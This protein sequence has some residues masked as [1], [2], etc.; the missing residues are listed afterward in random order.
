VADTRQTT[1]ARETP[2]ESATRW[3]PLHEAPD[4][5]QYIP[6]HE[7]ERT[8]LALRNA[9]A[10]GASRLAV[11]GPPGL[12]KTLLLRLLEDQTDR[13]LR[14]FYIPFASLE[15]HDLA[16]WVLALEGRSA[17]S[18]PERE[19][20]NVVAARHRDRDER[21][22][23]LVDEAQGIGVDT[24][25]RLAHWV[26]E[27]GGA[28]AVVLAG[29]AGA[30]VEAALRGLGAE[31]RFELNTP[32]LEAELAAFADALVADLALS[33]PRRIAVERMLERDLW[34]KT[35]GNPRL[36][37]GEILRAL[38]APLA[39]GAQ[40]PPDP[41]PAETARSPRLESPTPP[42][43]SRSTSAAGS[44]GSSRAS[45]SSVWPRTGVALVLG[46]LIA[47]WAGSRGFDHPTEGGKVPAA[48][49]SHAPLVPEV[50]PFAGPPRLDS[51]PAP[52][53]RSGPLR[54]PFAPPSEV[55]SALAAP[56]LVTVAINA[57]PWARVR[58]DGVEVGVTPIGALRLSPGL[59]RFAAEFPDGRLVEREV[60]VREGL[61]VVFP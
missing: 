33:A 54:S 24:A 12:G 52:P 13:D 32:I 59:R 49:V 5:R 18:A 50:P 8:L 31:L 9:L 1:R 61:R 23:L 26:E 36:V 58:V 15:P 6:R 41:P 56:R 29:I 10:A 43:F 27:S 34:A 37:K 48:E 19:F 42:G 11:V 14:A 47:L 2:H 38:R 3:Q 53:V 57:V 25:K 21:T 7:M 20:L 55:A 30:P 17:L 40:A 60:E 45:G 4:P 16:R 44:S 35:G 28:L 22:L 39:T 51:H 46:G